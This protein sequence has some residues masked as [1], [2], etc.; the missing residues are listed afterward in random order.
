MLGIN[1]AYIARHG[2]YQ[3][4]GVDTKTDMSYVLSKCPDIIESTIKAT[5]ILYE[6]PIEKNVSYW[7]VMEEDLIKSDLFRKNYLFITNVPYHSV[8]RSLFIRKDFYEGLKNRN[9]IN[10]IPVENTVLYSKKDD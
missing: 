4:R 2:R 1:D 3:K 10:V 9:K 6:Q 7:R 8:D 5:H